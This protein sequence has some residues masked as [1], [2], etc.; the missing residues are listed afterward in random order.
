MHMCMC[1]CMCIHVHVHVHVHVMYVCHMHMSCMS[2]V[3]L[4]VCTRRFYLV[5]EVKTGSTDRLFSGQSA[6]VR[7][8]TDRLSSL[9]LF[10]DFYLVF[11]NQLSCLSDFL[12]LEAHVEG[13]ATFG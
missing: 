4:S 9:A 11:I 7:P 8:A 13:A 12:P 2:H 1:M 6:E 5:A 10:A 3:C